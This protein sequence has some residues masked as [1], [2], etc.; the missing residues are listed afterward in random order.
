MAEI[1]E[2]YTVSAGENTMYTAAELDDILKTKKA[3]LIYKRI[4]DAVFALIALAVCL[5]PMIII[6]IVIKLDSPGPV[7]YKQERLGQGGRTFTMYKFRSMRLNAE[8][9][10]PKWAAENDNRCTKIGHYLR[11]SR[12]DELPQFI[13]IL[14]G[15]MSFVGPRPERE[16]FY[17]E[18][19]KYI[20]NFRDRLKVKPGLTGHAQVN[21]GY[22]LKP[23]EKIVY[24][25]DYIA[26]QSVAADIEIIIKTIVVI[27][28]HAGAR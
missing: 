14:K 19:E 2:T 16:Y 26:H 11:L 1:S 28:T 13:N 22:K 27:I 10:G 6:G 5:V 21:G 17:N 4:F 12:L 20:P 7:I 24:D 18:F 15:D 25:I 8:A 9:G 23:E 3:F